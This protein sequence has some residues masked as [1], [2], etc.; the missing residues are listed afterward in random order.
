MVSSLY[1]SAE[2][3]LRVGMNMLNRPPSKLTGQYTS[4]DVEHFKC[5]FGVAPII[6]SV[7]CDLMREHTDM[8]NKIKPHHILWGLVLLKMYDTEKVLCDHVGARDEKNFRKWAWEV[9]GWLADLEPYVVSQISDRNSKFQLL[10]CCLFRLTELSMHLSFGQI[11]ML[12]EDRHNGVPPGEKSACVDGTDCPTQEP[13]PFSSRNYSHKFKSAGLR[14]QVTT[15]RQGDIINVDGPHRPGTKWG[16]EKSIFERG[17]MTYLDEGEKCEG[18][19]YYRKQLQD[20]FTEYSNE[21]ER[22][23]ASR[24]RARHESMNGRLKRF[25]ILTTKF[26]AKPAFQKHSRA[27]RAIAVL[28]QLEIE[29]KSSLFEL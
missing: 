1:F 11:D 27:F 20:I 8:P 2:V 18:D 16:S 6:V 26:R 22:N 9:V 25:Q 10:Y 21:E 13:Q 5:T 14:Y 4:D 19:K 24:F 3:F 7:A 17:L 29:T 23:F 28:C 12:W 15:S